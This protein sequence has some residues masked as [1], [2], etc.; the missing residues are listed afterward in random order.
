[1]SRQRKGQDAFTEITTLPSDG[2]GP[3]IKEADVTPALADAQDRSVFL[4]NRLLVNWPYLGDTDLA[5][6]DAFFS[7]AD[8]AWYCNAG[9]GAAVNDW[10]VSYDFGDGTWTQSAAPAAAD[11][12]ASA[13]APS[14]DFI[15][16][17]I[18]RV[19]Y[20]Y[21]R[22]AYA[23]LMVTPPV[24][25]T[26]NL[27]VSPSGG[28]CAYEPTAAKWIAVYR[29][30]ASGMK[31]ENDS[32]GTGAFT[33][34]TIPAA[35]TGYTGGN[36]PRIN[37]IAGHALACFIDETSTPK[38]NV[39]RSTDGGG[40][41]STNVQVTPTGFTPTHVSRPVYDASAN[42]GNGAWFIMM[43]A[44]GKTEIIESTD[45]G[46]SWSSVFTSTAIFGHD[47]ACNRGCLALIGSDGRVYYS[48]DEGVTFK[49]F[50]RYL[51]VTP[52]V[53]WVIRAGGGGFLALNDAEGNARSTI[54]MG[55]GGAP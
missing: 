15:T 49:F 4:R 40:T 26:N 52:A 38:L 21:T 34:A 39:I 13:I 31:A 37:A 22:S 10:A 32:D 17:G 12:I 3:H 14:G 41:W 27:S 42:S 19:V 6:G 28:D 2:D 33:V 16:I 43:A 7:E 54:R 35:W 53:R 45:H 1:M 11:I 46:A 36:D 30:G 47:M 8:Q 44:A 55:S 51:Y 25:G 24:A 5:T 29:N 48:F 20:K 9:I 23:N 50:W 18:S